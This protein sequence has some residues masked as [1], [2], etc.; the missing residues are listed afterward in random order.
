[1]NNTKGL[2]HALESKLAACRNFAKDQA[3]RKNY[4]TNINGNLINGDISNYSHSLH[5]SY[6]DKAPL[7]AC[8]VQDFQASN[9]TICYFSEHSRTVNGLDPGDVK[10]IT[11][12]PPSSSPSSVVLSM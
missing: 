1:M 3:A 7:T 8:T 12:P 5:T 4:I 10:N 6:F 9:S 11:V 2:M